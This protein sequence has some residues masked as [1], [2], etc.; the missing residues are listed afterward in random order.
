MP[1]FHA[2]SQAL[3]KRRQA[4]V[5]PARF[6]FETIIPKTSAS[7][8]FAITALRWRRILEESYLTNFSGKRIGCRTR[9]FV[10][11]ATPKGWKSPLPYIQVFIADLVPC[12]RKIAAEYL[13]RICKPGIPS[14]DYTG[15]P[16]A[17]RTAQA[18][19]VYGR[20]GQ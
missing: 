10:E 3:S 20:A 18:S 11:S 17:L 4:P 6:C 15:F 14:P 12:C 1:L 8:D 2:S 19:G 7:R 13:T 16:F 5:F 9:F